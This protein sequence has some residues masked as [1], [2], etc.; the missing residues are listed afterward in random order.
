MGNS[1]RVRTMD[2]FL[3]AR[4]ILSEGTCHSQM[5]DA[6]ETSF[7]SSLPWPR[8]GVAHGGEARRH[9]EDPAAHRE[10]E[11]CGATNLLRKEKT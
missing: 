3:S 5:E 8:F 2:L 7:Y 6:T 9:P 11:P 4:I 10:L 1:L